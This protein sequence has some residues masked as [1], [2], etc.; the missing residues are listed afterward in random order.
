MVVS[1]RLAQWIE[2]QTVNLAVAGSTPVPT[3]QADQRPATNAGRRCPA[4][5]RVIGHRRPASDGDED[6]GPTAHWGSSRRNRRPRKHTVVRWQHGRV[7]CSAWIPL[8]PASGKRQRMPGDSPQGF[9]PSATS[10]AE[11]AASP[12]AMRMLKRHSALVRVIAAGSAA[13]RLYE[14]KQER[15]M[16]GRRKEGEGCSSS[17]PSRF[18]VTKRACTSVTASSR[19]CWRLAGTGSSTRWARSTSQHAVGCQSRRLWADANP[20]P[21]S[22]RRGRH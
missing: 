15:P 7:P 11:T 4:G 1:T 18:A 12:Q 8:S 19:A 3:P 9:G 17:R 21:V 13:Q 22:R 5:Q 20:L 2:H 14:T 6:S 16:K 10:P